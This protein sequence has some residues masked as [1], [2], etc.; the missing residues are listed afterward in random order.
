MT[1]THTRKKFHTATVG[2]AIA[3]MAAPA[4]LFLSA[5]NAQAVIHIF[6]RRA[7]AMVARDSI[8][9]RTRPA[10]PIQASRLGSAALTPKLG[11]APR[12]VHHR[13]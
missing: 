12:P 9:S 2:A 3:T 13:R 4:L 8:P 7:V 11:S 5:G 6:L 10:I 1:T